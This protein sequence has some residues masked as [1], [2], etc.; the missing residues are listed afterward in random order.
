MVTGFLPSLIYLKYVPVYHYVLSY[1]FIF[2]IIFLNIFI[3]YNF[4]YIKNW[5]RI[6]TNIFLE[7]QF[8]HKEN[9]FID[10]TYQETLFQGHI[11]YLNK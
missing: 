9:R 11:K 6:L 10:T 5:F 2:G 7:I 3:K 4:G 8:L 1:T